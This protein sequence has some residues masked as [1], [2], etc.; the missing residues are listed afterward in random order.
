MATKSWLKKNNVEYTEKNV[1]KP[2]EAEELLALGYR[3]TPV[4]VSDK[5]TVV[6]YNPTKL[7]EVLL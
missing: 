2:E 6:G 4:I 1:S 3:M 5:G 7:S